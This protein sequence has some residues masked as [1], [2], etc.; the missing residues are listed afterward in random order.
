MNDRNEVHIGL[1]QLVNDSNVVSIGMLTG[2]ELRSLPAYGHKPFKRDNERE[3]V[4]RLLGT[5]ES[6]ADTPSLYCHP[7]FDDRILGTRRD[8]EEE[9]SYDVIQDPW[10]PTRIR[11]LA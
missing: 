8:L 3:L 4:A 10:G 6:A 5:V 1:A 2:E 11:G 7:V 9:L